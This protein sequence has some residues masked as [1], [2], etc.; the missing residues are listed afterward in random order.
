L[1]DLIADDSLV[2]I[3]WSELDVGNRIGAGAFGEGERCEKR[4]ENKKM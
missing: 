3:P 1:V 4:C 2:S